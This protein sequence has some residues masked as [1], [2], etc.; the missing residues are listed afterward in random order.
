MRDEIYALGIVYIFTDGTLSP[1]FH[2]PGRP[3]IDNTDND[4]GNNPYISLELDQWDSIDVTG[5]EN[6]FNPDKSARWQVYN[7]YTVND[8]EDGGLMGYYQVSTT[9]P[10]IDVC[11]DDHADGYW[12]R[13]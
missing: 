4:Y 6:V 12:G 8:D 3:M 1:V 10:D 2:I 13:D 5:D 9:Y 11:D 7:T